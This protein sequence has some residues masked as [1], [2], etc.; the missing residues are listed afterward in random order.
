MKTKIGHLLVYRLSDKN[1]LFD[2]IGSVPMSW[3]AFDA[4]GQPKEQ[5]E[6][7]VQK[8]VEHELCRRVGF[9]L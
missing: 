1:I 8:I 6:M 4:I 3:H 7:R 9:D 2:K 5:E